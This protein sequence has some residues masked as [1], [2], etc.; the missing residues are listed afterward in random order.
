VI[1]IT[2]ICRYFETSLII[3]INLFSQCPMKPEN[4]HVLIV[5]DDPVTRSLLVAYFEKAGFYAHESTG[6]KGTWNILQKRDVDLV[7]LDVNLPGEDGFSILRK[8]RANSDIG[9]IMV[10]SRHSQMDRIRG[11]KN[12]A[13][14]YIIKPF[15]EEELLLRARN[16][17][18]RSLASSIQ[19]D[20]DRYENSLSSKYKYE[21]ESSR[22]QNI[23]LIEQQD[24]LIKA[25]QIS[26]IG[27]WDWDIIN[28]TFSWSDEIYRIFGLA[29]QEFGATYEAFLTAVHPNDRE[30]VKNE[31]NKA[32]DDSSYEYK[33][34][35]RVA[36]TDGKERFVQERGKVLRDA[37][38][39]PIRMIGTLRDITDRKIAE[40]QEA[41]AVSS[42]IAISALLETGLEQLSLQK[43]LTI[44]LDI[45]LAVPWLGLLNKG[46]IFLFDKDTD[47][48]I[49]SCQKN[50]SEYLIK[51]CAR[52]LSGH[53]LC[54]RAAQSRKLVFSN[55]L[56]HR[57]ETT[58][59]GIQE[60]GHLC[61][62]ILSK[63]NL[64][65]VIN[66]YVPH[67]HVHIPEEEAFTSTMVNT[68]AGLIERRRME[69]QIAQTEERLRHSAYHDI[70]TKLPNRMY[71]TELLEH[72][73]ARAKRDD[74]QL[75]VLFMDL[76]H[77]KKVNDTLGHEIGDLL[78]FEAAQRIKECL[79]ES[80]IL[81]RLGG[82]EFVAL[83]TTIT[84]K[85]EAGNV[86]KRIIESLR[87]PFT[88]SGNSCQIGSSIGI[89]I[90]PHDGQ[91]QKM[92]LIHSDLAMYEIKKRGKNDYLFFDLGMLNDGGQ[93]LML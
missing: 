71:L 87:V 84:D 49:M 24:S 14:D 40:E 16:L 55:C 42:R 25:Q 73:I 93:K 7:I 67:G 86:A 2:A 79:R 32:L 54:G 48:L 75:A 62:P 72:S 70:L 65:G 45:I 69:E 5:E 30:N 27:S 9:I 21:L 22:K 15:D 85:H 41:R 60:H 26:K 81:A 56:D 44:A 11:L 58:Y 12:G 51:S 47:H 76:D 89:A 38:G 19:D 29:P 8:L 23:R 3:D 28:D 6:D 18:N 13:D 53:C 91:S 10:T 39:C 57:H 50:L 31:V 61:V 36:H 35:H 20:G 82:D 77:F 66:L 80:D 90:F 33:V 43:Q 64:L 63:G 88:L 68:L 34:N 78:L 4:R 74:T 92:L 1:E 52:V 17:L 46:S 59:E 83:L 37:E